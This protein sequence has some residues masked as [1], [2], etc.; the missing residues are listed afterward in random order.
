MAHD[1][2]L[3]AGPIIATQYLGYHSK[4]KKQAH[5]IDHDPFFG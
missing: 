2:L 5:N 1:F 4:G 3:V